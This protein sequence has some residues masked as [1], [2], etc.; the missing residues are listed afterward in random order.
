MS[1]EIKVPPMLLSKQ[2]G[3]LT[4]AHECRKACFLGLAPR[5]LAE[6][7]GKLGLSGQIDK[8]TEP[9]RRSGTVTLTARHL[10]MQLS[11]DP[12]LRDGLILRYRIGAA[13]RAPLREATVRMTELK[14]EGALRHLVHQMRS[15]LD[16]AARAVH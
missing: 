16:E 7:A 8:D 2:Y 11:E 12:V 3:G 14:E 13:E 5:F 1:D 4:T 15:A 6:V 10:R 9:K